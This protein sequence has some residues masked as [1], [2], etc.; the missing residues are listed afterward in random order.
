MA[1]ELVHELAR[2]GRMQ[3]G[4]LAAL[5]AEIA[6]HMGFAIRAVAGG[7]VEVDLRVHG[8]FRHSHTNQHVIHLIAKK[9]HYL[10]FQLRDWLP[11]GALGFKQF[12]QYLRSMPW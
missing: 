8:N 11:M 1:D 2:A 5:M 10:C 7:L 3:H 4:L 9:H 6:G 12:E